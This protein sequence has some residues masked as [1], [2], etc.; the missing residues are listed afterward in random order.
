MTE[1][2]NGADAWLQLGVAGAALFILLVVVYM[3]MKSNS[4][5]MSQYADM[6]KQSIEMQ[7]NNINIQNKSIDQLCSKIDK[8]ADTTTEVIKSLAIAETKISN[9]MN[10]NDKHFTKISDK[11]ELIDDKL[12]KVNNKLDSII[13][14]K[15]G[16]EDK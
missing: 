10:N 14:Y 12:D 13:K 7:N 5:T 16:I 2:F 4:K 9:E 3:V 15:C 11:T 1:I 8:L 6:Q